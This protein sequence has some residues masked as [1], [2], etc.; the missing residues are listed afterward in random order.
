MKDYS[1]QNGKKF[2]TKGFK[3]QCV[4]V[5]S[6]EYI[7]SEESVS[8]I[9]LKNGRKIDQT[10]TIREFETELSDF[11]FYRI[12]ENLIV[13]GRY[14]TEIDT[15]IN[16]RILKIGNFEFK[17]AKNRMKNFINWINGIPN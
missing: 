13:N 10:K 11:G 3:K 12:R 17:I 8:T 6:I 16:K 4:N 15:K 1:K 5:I 7:K 9:V 14:I 2:F